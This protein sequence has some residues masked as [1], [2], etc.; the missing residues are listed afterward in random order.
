MVPRGA[1][2]R[3]MTPLAQYPRRLRFYIWRWATRSTELYVDRVTGHGEHSMSYSLSPTFPAGELVFFIPWRVVAAIPARRSTT[4]AGRLVGAAAGGCTMV[5]AP[6]AP[7][8]FWRYSGSG[9][10][11]SAGDRRDRRCGATGSPAS[12]ARL[13]RRVGGS[14]SDVA[15]FTP[16]ACIEK[17]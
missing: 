9:R 11:W 1:A 4:G 16:G 14:Q 5:M 12:T 10:R 8:S 3:T 2:P 15:K 17:V 13:E 6:P 7:I